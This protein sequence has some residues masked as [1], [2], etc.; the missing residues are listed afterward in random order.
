MRRSRSFVLFITLAVLYLVSCDSSGDNSQVPSNPGME[1]EFSLVDAF[2]NLSF[3]RSLDIQ[4]PG[5]G[6]NRLFVV[7]QKGVILVINNIPANNQIEVQ[8]N[9]LDAISN[10]FLDIQDQVL[11]DESELGLLGL[12]FHPDTKIT[13]SFI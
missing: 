11:F 5:D 6:S 12:T 8:L 3:D 7:E 13:V 9:G 1:N 4:N 10:V 2:P